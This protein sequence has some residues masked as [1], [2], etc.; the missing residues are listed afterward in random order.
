MKSYRYSIVIVGFLALMSVTGCKST[1]P[2]EAVRLN[3]QAQV[4]YR[5]GYFDQAMTLLQKSVD[6]DYENPASHYWLG[7]CYEQKNNI[8]KAIFEYEM[9]VRFSPTM[10]LAQMA[11]VTALHRQGR[12]EESIQ[13][14]KVFCKSKFGLACDIIAI[15]KQFAEKGM[16]QQAILAYERAQEVEPNNA[17]PSVALADFYL[18]KGQSKLEIS[19]LTKAFT[20]DPHYP[21]LA[22]RLG[23]RGYR[24]KIPETKLTK[25]PSRMDYELSEM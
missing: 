6:Y 3:R 21:G 18:D 2:L 1:N 16:D 4:Y 11:L 22:R 9:A 19:S 10:E 7:Q 12:I 25:P 8:T 17:V 14:A 5:E 24:V 20:I 15:A 23:E 13:A